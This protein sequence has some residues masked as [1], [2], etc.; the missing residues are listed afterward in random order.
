ELVSRAIDIRETG[1]LLHHR[2]RRGARS[3]SRG[4]EGIGAEALEGLSFGFQRAAEEVES[5]L[6]AG[7][8]ESLPGWVVPGFE[9][10][11]RA[12]QW[13][14]RVLLPQ[15]V[16]IGIQSEVRGEPI[17]RFARLRQRVLEAFDGRIRNPPERL[18]DIHAGESRPDF[19]VESEG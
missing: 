13:Q 3:G 4:H 16:E 17:S 8:R 14:P 6:P 11:R 2:S 9:P 1:S 10:E 7:E 12:R 19:R 18:A 5:E 15:Q